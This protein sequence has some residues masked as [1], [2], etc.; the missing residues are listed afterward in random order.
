MTGDVDW[1]RIEKIKGRAAGGLR[2][3]ER[4]APAKASPN[5]WRQ[6]DWPTAVANG[7]GPVDVLIPIP[8]PE[9]PSWGSP[10]PIQEIAMT[11]TKRKKT[12]KRDT[13]K[14]KGDREKQAL[15][16]VGVRPN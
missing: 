1:P 16:T 5:K 8:S 11:K 9:L 10:K 15:A 13:R 3:A 14:A 2:G 4:R 6:S 7:V 12:I